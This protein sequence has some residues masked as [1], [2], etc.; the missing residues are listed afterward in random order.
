MPNDYADYEKQCERVRQENAK[1]LD[2]FAG[3]L[4]AKGLEEINISGL[5]M[6]SIKLHRLVFR[7]F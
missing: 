7:F 6:V 4:A 3:L 2:E 5:K 1:L